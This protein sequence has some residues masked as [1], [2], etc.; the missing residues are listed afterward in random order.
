[1]SSN[2]APETERC[3]NRTGGTIAAGALVAIE[4]FYA[5]FNTQQIV[6]ASANNT[7]RLA[8]G[9]LSVAKTANQTGY[10]L[11]DYILE[12]SATAVVDTSAGAIGDDVYLSPTV[13]GSWTLTRPTALNQDVQPVGSILT[14]HATNGRIRFNFQAGGIMGSR[15]GE[16]SSSMLADKPLY[17][18]ALSGWGWH[19]LTGNVVEGELVTVGTRVYGFSAVPVLVPGADV[20][21]DVSAGLTPAVA[22]AALAAAVNGDALTEA[23]AVVLGGDVVGFTSAASGAGA[24]GSIA[25]VTNSVNGIVSAATA[26]GAR[27]ANRQVRSGGGYFLKATDV[28]ALL[29]APGTAEVIIGTFYS[30][31]QPQLVSIQAFRPAG[32]SPNLVY[33]PVSLIAGRF[34]M[35]LVNANQWALSWM[36]PIGGSVLATGD[37]L[38]WDVNLNPGTP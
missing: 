22:N 26:A 5:P 3:V 15:P 37:L 24:L 25:L 36:E 20:I 17:D 12:G 10:F 27:D 19:R 31:T 7:G 33:D 6:P 4:G 21:V 1:M 29:T 2:L 34:R 23:D 9:Y 38:A 14:V 28:A 11:R 18:I 16:I 30:A 8:D 32:A 13:P 35:R